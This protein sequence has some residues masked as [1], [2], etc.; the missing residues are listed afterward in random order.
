MRFHDLRHTFANL[1]LY[2]AK[3]NV[4]S[5]ALGHTNV[6]LY[7][8]RLFAYNKR[9]AS[10]GYGIT[11]RGATVGGSP[12]VS[13]IRQQLRLSISRLVAGYTELRGGTNE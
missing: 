9:D 12:S 2:G 1:L 13:G 11:R 3:L 10:G 7:D 4:I 8:R 5:E 6:A